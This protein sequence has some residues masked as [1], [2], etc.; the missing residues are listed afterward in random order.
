MLLLFS[1]LSFWLCP[2]PPLFIH[3]C[4]FFFIS[5]QG[6]LSLCYDKL[7]Y[8]L[9]SILGMWNKRNLKRLQYKK[10]KKGKKNKSILAIIWI[11]PFTQDSAVVYSLTGEAKRERPVVKKKRSVF[12]TTGH[13]EFYLRHACQRWRKSHVFYCLSRS[14]HTIVLTTVPWSCQPKAF[15]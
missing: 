7:P 2:P 4:T 8:G 13:L 9:G 12:S 5:K 14:T 1:F 3:L 10:K 15:L 11:V 6:N